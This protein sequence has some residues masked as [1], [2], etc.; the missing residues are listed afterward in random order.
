MC[1]YVYLFTCLYLY[2]TNYKYVYPPIRLT[3]KL[4]YNKNDDKN[5]VS[6]PSQE[7]VS[8]NA[9]GNSDISPELHASLVNVIDELTNSRDKIGPIKKL[10][11]LTQSSP[12]LDVSL[13]L[14]R[15]SSVFRKYVLDTLQEMDEKRAR[16]EGRSAAPAPAGSAAGYASTSVPDYDSENTAGPAPAPARQPSSSGGQGNEGFEAMRIIEGLKKQQSHSSE[17][18]R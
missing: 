1:L 4:G 14:Q 11:F 15:T 2:L 17:S 6:A 12:A 3:A 9:S 13:Y 18:P 16:H 10:Y 5:E 8:S 7:E